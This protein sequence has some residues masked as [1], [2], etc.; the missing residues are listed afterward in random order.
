MESYISFH[1]G[2]IYEVTGDNRRNET[3]YRKKRLNKEIL[4]RSLLNEQAKLIDFIT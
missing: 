4:K 2:I 1:D 3:F